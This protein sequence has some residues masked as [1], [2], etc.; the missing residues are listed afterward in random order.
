MDVSLHPGDVIFVPRS[1]LT[2][3]GFV[4]QQLAPFLTMGSLATIAVH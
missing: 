3:V 4:M 2:K 1:G